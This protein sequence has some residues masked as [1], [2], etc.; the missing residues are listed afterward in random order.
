LTIEV[1]SLL[2]H[3]DHR[4]RVF[5]VL[6]PDHLTNEEFGQL[7]VFTAVPGATKGNHYHKR[8]TEWFCVVCGS[9][10]LGLVD[11]ATGERSRIPLSAV[12]PAVVRIA[13]GIAHAVRNTGSEELIVLAYVSEPFVPSDSDTFPFEIP[14]S[15]AD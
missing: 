11:L 12:E 3:P 14:A 4:G 15:D 8:K 6:R 1:R 5:E 2:Q 13:P 7:Y 9:G 10:E